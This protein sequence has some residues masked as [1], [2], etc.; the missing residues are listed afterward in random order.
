MPKIKF[1]IPV[2]EGNA[3]T[4]QFQNLAAISTNDLNMNAPSNNL[5]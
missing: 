1:F 4:Q 5:L 2:N 3:Q